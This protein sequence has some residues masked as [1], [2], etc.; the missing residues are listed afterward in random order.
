MNREATVELARHG[1]LYPAVI[2]HGG[3]TEERQ[4]LALRLASILLCDEEADKRPCGVCRHCSRIVWPGKDRESFHPDF[5]VLERD[6]KT[7]T[8]VEGTKAFLQLAQVSPFEARGQVFVIANADTLTGEAA[9]ALLKSLEEPSVRSPRHFLLLS[10][11]QFDLLPTVRSRSM[12]VYL[13][14]TGGVHDEQLAQLAD[15]FAADVK[16]YLETRSAVHLLAAAAV[17]VEA[18]SWQDPRASESWTLA[19]SIVKESRSRLPAVTRRPVLDLA[20]DLLSGWRLRLRGIQAQRILEG[21]VARHL[22]QGS[23]VLN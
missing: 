9:N 13:G 14:A 23:K 20:E 22:S 6:L 15:R 16:K 18:G 21:M 19:A 12:P 7:S 17:L 5:R 4:T 1:Q 3:T 10:P 11:S 2:L 8:S